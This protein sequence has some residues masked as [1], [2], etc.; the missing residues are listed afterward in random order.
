MGS[1]GGAID[2]ER[3]KKQAFL[4]LF[5][6]AMDKL[7]REWLRSSADIQ[8]LPV[9]LIPIPDLK[10]HSTAPG[11][12]SVFLSGITHSSRARHSALPQV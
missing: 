4:A 9:F 10:I 11:L 7:V 5:G 1:V 2:L 8:D 3:S 12:G 6:T